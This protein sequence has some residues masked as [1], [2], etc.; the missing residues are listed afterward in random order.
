[1]AFMAALDRIVSAA[2]CWRA[3][4]A[5]I[6]EPESVFLACQ[7]D[8]LES[9]H[10]ESLAQLSRIIE[11]RDDRT[12]EHTLRVA[13]LSGLIAQNLHMSPGEAREVL[14]A[15]PVHDIGK[16]V[17][18]DR[19]LLKPGPLDEEE[20]TTM[21]QHTVFASK[22]M[23]DSTSDLIRVTEQIARHHHERWDGQGY[24][25][26]L[27]AELIPLPARIVAVADTFDAMMNDRPYRTAVPI[28]RVQQVIEE[29]SGRQFDPQV[30]EALFGVLDSNLWTL[31][32]YLTPFSTMA[33]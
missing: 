9:A 31:P 29:E 3:H 24:P 6:S 12:G 23:G 20:Q 15:A 1:M 32:R 16:V 10:L 14:R 18:P 25:D 22:I 4:N 33:P 8:I 13:R 2:L 7:A 26:G 19:I 28:E 21:Q 17:V 11:L 27:A 5:K 30:V